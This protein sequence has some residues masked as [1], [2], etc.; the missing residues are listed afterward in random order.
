MATKMVAAWS[1]EEGFVCQIVNT[2]TL[3]GYSLSSE[4]LDYEIVDEGAARVNCHP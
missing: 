3:L 2:R 1:A 4:Q